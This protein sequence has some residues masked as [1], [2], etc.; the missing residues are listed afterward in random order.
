M[1]YWS[2]AVQPGT[3]MTAHGDDEVRRHK[4]CRTFLLRPRARRPSD[5]ELPP[6][7]SKSTYTLP[8]PP[9][10]ARRP[11]K[12]FSTFSFML[13]SISSAMA[14]MYVHENAIQITWWRMGGLLS[15]GI[16]SYS[17]YLIH[18]PIIFLVPNIYH[19]FNIPPNPL[20]VF[21]ICVFMVIP[22]FWCSR[23]A[24]KLVELPSMNMGYRILAMRCPRRE[25]HVLFPRPGCR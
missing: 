6:R 15:L 23:F 24:R 13:F 12:P 3:A 7:R 5:P 19:Y 4:G 1:G 18:Q 21:T 14:I 16:V 20:T 10:T 2:C 11:F 22:L 9:E 8:H 17:F 25:R